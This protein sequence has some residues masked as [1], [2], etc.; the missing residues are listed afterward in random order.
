MGKLIYTALASMDGYIADDEGNFEW[1]E[2]KEDVYRFVNSIEK[3]NGIHLYGKKMYNTMSA[4]ENIPDIEKQPEYIREFEAAWKKAKKNIYSSTLNEIKT[5]NT[6]LKKT[7]EKDKVEEIKKKEPGNLGIGGANLASQA[8][9]QGLIDE[10]FLIVFPIMIGSGKKWI[11]S[12]RHEYLKK[13]EIKEF[14]REILML[15]Y[16][17]I[18]DQ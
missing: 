16:R 18:Y 1:A 11:N 3:K 9:S 7:F 14:E 17:V 15:H 6:I 8:L 2:P 12:P 13:I 10:V 5:S 4:W